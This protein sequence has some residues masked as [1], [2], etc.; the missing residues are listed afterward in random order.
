MS[1]ERESED[2]A[3]VEP[4]D[5]PA[6]EA[7]EGGSDDEADTARPD[8]DPGVDAA[9]DDEAAE[10][11]APS[12]NGEPHEDTPTGGR[13]LE[14]TNGGAAVADS[15]LA[16]TLLAGPLVEADDPKRPYAYP[17]WA[18]VLVSFFVLYHAAVLTVENLPAKGLSK[19]LMTWFNKKL[20]ARDYFQATGNTQSW[21]MFAPN[22]H[23]SNIFM[24]VLVKDADGEIFDLKHDI[25]GK[26]TYPYLFYDRMGKVNRRIV[27]Q[28]GYRRHYAAWVCREWER[29]HGGQAADEVIFVK[30]WTQVPHPDE[31][32]KRW[33]QKNYDLRYLGYHPLELKLHEREADTFRC[34][35]TRQ[36]QLPNYLR[37]RYGLPLEDE[38]YFRD[39]TIRTWY[40]EQ[41]Q[42]REAEERKAR[43][44]ERRR[45]P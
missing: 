33:K 37:E 28:K 1:D 15:G 27:D 41:E 19:G 44:Q 29:T 30:M 24:K 26:R 22:P 38:N 23:R 34:A 13:S 3:K 36:A 12:D 14:D 32:I 16:S 5:T 18:R 17:L 11:G 20:Q 8:D 35:T 25:Y 45:D 21:A 10:E 9:S 6:Q 7:A 42:Q 40:V 43:L 2:G 31:V 4:A 39:Q